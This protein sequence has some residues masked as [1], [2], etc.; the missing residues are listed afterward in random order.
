MFEIHHS[1]LRFVVSCLFL[2]VLATS[3]CRK[4]EPQYSRGVNLLY[5]GEPTAFYS[6]HYPSEL[7]VAHDDQ[8]FLLALD[9]ERIEIS[10]LMSKKSGGAWEEKNVADL[11]TL[12]GEHLQYNRLIF[13]EKGLVLGRVYKP[14]E[15]VGDCYVALLAP[16]DQMSEWKAF[17]K[18]VF[19]GTGK[20][21]QELS[22]SSDKALSFI[23]IGN[24]GDYSG[25][26]TRDSGRKWHNIQGALPFPKSKSFPGEQEL[27][28]FLTLSAEGDLRLLCRGSKEI[29]EFR[30]RDDELFEF[31]TVT[32]SQSQDWFGS[33]ETRPE[34]IYRCYTWRSED[35]KQPTSLVFSRG[36]D[37]ETGWEGDAIICPE[38][39]GDIV[40]LHISGKG[41]FIVCSW[42]NKDHKLQ[43]S[44]SKDGGR[45][46]SPVKALKSE[47]HEVRNPASY[48]RDVWLSVKEGLD[49]SER[50][51]EFLSYKQFIVGS[52]V[53]FVRSRPVDDS[54]Y[55]EL[56]VDW[57]RQI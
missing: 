32:K 47:N 4:F 29:F 2:L 15:G 30:S 33:N 3:S 21:P 26:I 36:E 41:D 8:L 23:Q 37:L 5:F 48:D 18:S 38:L 13:T 19:T 50:L 54:I 51:D 42:L 40:D 24:R 16:D 31:R 22:I 39:E 25:Q 43:Y 6:S 20:S 57:G 1:G 14:Y 49:G 12:W 53:V 44:A 27:R 52:D 46:W 7:V 10:R 28:L 35:K 45:K 9:T 56:L 11:Q 34:I 17:N 55:R